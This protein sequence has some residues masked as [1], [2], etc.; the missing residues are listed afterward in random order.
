MATMQSASYAD[1][2]R[3]IKEENPFE[4]MMSRFNIAAEVLGLDEEIYN[5]L[6]TPTRQVIVNVPVTMD[7]GKV[8]VFEGYRVIHSTILGPSKGGIRFAPVDGDD[9]I[10][11][12]VMQ[13]FIERIA[14]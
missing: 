13:V 7:D 8:R 14:G 11:G 6:K 5:V 2:L 1:D 4:S 3:E 9:K 10:C 12:G